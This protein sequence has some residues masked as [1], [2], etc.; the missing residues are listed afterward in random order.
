[1]VDVGNSG[2]EPTSGE[3]V[4]KEKKRIVV[5]RQRKGGREGKRKEKLYIVEG[6]AR[7]KQR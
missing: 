6:A 4:G 7:T 3:V 2:V 1:M 5:E